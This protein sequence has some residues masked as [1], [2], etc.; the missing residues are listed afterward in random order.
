MVLA[1][2]QELPGAFPADD[3]Y[4]Y[5][6]VVKY[7]IDSVVHGTITSDTIYVEQYKPKQSRAVAGKSSGGKT[8]GNLDL[9]RAGDRHYLVLQPSDSVWSGAV[10]DNFPQSTAPRWWASWTDRI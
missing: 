8:G 9:M 2:L 3:L 10:E 4:D 5:A 6:Y 1:T 7:A